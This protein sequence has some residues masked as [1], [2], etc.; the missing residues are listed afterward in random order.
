MDVEEAFRKL[1]LESNASVDD[2]HS[3]YRDLALKYHPDMGGNDN[4]MSELSEARDIAIRSIENKLVTLK[5][6]NPIVASTNKSADKIQQIESH[7]NLINHIIH[8]CTRRNISVKR[9]SLVTGSASALCF[10]ILRQIGSFGYNTFISPSLIVFISNMLIPF[11]FLLGCMY[12]ISSISVTSIENLVE[13]INELL[14][15]KITYFEILYFFDELGSRD[16]IIKENFTE[17]MLK[18]LIRSWVRSDRESYMKTTF[19][20]FFL[21][22]RHSE[23][24]LV[25][26][27]I[28]VIGT[29]YF[30][31]I[32]ISKGV[33]IGI[34]DEHISIIENRPLVE[35]SLAIKG[36]E[37]P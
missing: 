12:V 31:R 37:T 24:D 23:T 34:L 28:Q 26:D 6:L 8:D 27:T 16:E 35:Y 2:I 17:R 32:F 14:G 5:D 25:K 3:K 20:A 21:S 10:F 7:K 19:N 13:D 1:E 33:G 4:E 9:F 30:V 15:D 36:Q 22:M 29:R 11:A 18:E